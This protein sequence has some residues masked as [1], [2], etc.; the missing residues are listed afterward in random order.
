MSQFMN[1][2]QDSENNDENYGRKHFVVIPVPAFAGIN[3][4]GNPGIK[5]NI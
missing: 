3:S 2:N 4:G 1:K 5:L